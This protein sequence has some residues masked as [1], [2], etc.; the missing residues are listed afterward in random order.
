MT[1]PARVLLGVA[2]GSCL[3]LFLHPASRR[4]M[5]G[6][7]PRP[8]QAAEI[9]NVSGP[10]KGDMPEPQSIADAALW[11]QLACDKLDLGQKLTSNELN[12]LVRLSKIMSTYS[13]TERRNAFWPQ[14]SAVF[15]DQ[16]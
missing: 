14:M 6:F 13:G 10:S 7:W 9:V 3:T 4:F 11:M 15:L 8:Y 16:L 2:L 12:S 1:S 5:T